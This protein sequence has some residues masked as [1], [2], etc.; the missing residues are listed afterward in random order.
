MAASCCRKAATFVSTPA[1]RARTIAGSSTTKTAFFDRHGVATIINAAGTL[2]RLSGSPLAPGVAAAM[3]EADHASVDLFQLQAHASRAIAAATGAKAGCVTSGAAA[4]LLLASAACLAGLD[5]ARMNRLPEAPERKEIVVARG[6]RNGYDH[7]V[8]A[9]GARLVEVG[10]PERHAGAGLR[11]AEAAE[12]RHAIGNATAAILYVASQDA[13]PS[14]PEVA[15]VAQAAGIPVIVDAAAELPPQA[16]LRRFLAEGA[17]L[18]AFSGGKAIGGP[19]GTGILCGRRD[20][21]ASA[22]LQSLDLDVA[23]AELNPPREFLDAGQLDGLP[24]QGIGRSCKVGKH[25]I[26]GLLAALEHFLLEGDADRHA[27]WLETCRL[28]LRGLD[29][30]PGTTLSLEGEDD[31]RRVPLATIAF[32]DAGSARAMRQRLLARRVPVHLKTASRAPD[33][34][35]VDPTCLRPHEIAPLVVAIRSEAD[36]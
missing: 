15:A 5:I 10:L 36:G 33:R 8:R 19:A 1:E 28:V 20:L 23:L 30:M 6:Q 14:L 32:S 34:L 21:V 3:A 13:E 25:E 11:E 27:R 24:R 16:N 12:Y 4:G 2:T 9:S 29:G 18:V 26:V 22:V 7:A 31:Q 17:D 35:F